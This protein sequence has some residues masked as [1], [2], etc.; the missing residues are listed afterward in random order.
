[1]EHK[2][3]N[4]VMVG[5]RLRA[6]LFLLVLLSMSSAAALAASVQAKTE[7]AQEPVFNS[8]VFIQESGREHERTLVF[9]HG[10]GDNGARDWDRI[11]AALANRFHI[12]T[13]DLP[14]FGRS[15]RKTLAY[16]PESYA[17]FLHWIITTY[18]EGHVTLIGHSMG[19]AIS[20]YY[21]AQHPEAVQ[22]M[23]LFDAAGV[24]HRGAL[25]RFM[26]TVPEDGPGNTELVRRSA[27]QVNEW[28]SAAIV[29]GETL[30]QQLGGLIDESRLRNIFV[31]DTPTTIA[32][33][34]LVATDFSSIVPNVAAPVFMIWGERDRVAPLRT[35]QLLERQLASARLATIADAAHVPM[36]E[37]PQRALALVEEFLNSEDPPWR[38][39]PPPAVIPRNAPELRCE[40][41]RDVA[42]TGVFSRVTIAKCESVRLSNVTASELVITDSKVDLVNVSIAGGAVAARVAN[43]LL[44]GTNVEWRADVGLDVTSSQMDLAGTE[45]TGN[46]HAIVSHGASVIICSLCQLNS[47]RASRP[48]HGVFELSDATYY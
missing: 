2:F 14:G 46:R 19:A 27:A 43:S 8:K 40:N 1:M 9:V 21:A 3:G 29:K 15:E 26:T 34:A 17:R 10:L 12:V 16:S 42:Y 18:T 35:G 25:L 24:L 6:A 5:E 11:I 23:I 22:R 32:G 4:I 28:I 39:A 48:W 31:K 20:L 41:K 44:S 36:S 47:G 13:F 7:W 45:L 38:A 37:T 33:A 30:T